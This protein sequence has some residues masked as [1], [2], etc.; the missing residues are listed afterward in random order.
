MYNNAPEFLNRLLLEVYKQVDAD[1][2]YFAGDLNAKL[3][4]LK[5]YTDIDNVSARVVLD[6]TENNHG[7]ALREFLLD[8]KCCVVNSRVT[9]QYDNYTFVSTRGTSVVDYFISPHDCLNQIQSCYVD[10]CSDIIT[11]LDAA[12]LVSDICR[13][14]DHSLLTISVLTSPYVELQSRMLGARNYE[15][16]NT[17]VPK[18]KVRNLPPD[19]MRSEHFCEIIVNLID[20]ISASRETQDCVDNMYNKL[21]GEIHKEMS[22]KLTPLSMGGKRKNTPYK[23]YWCNELSNLWKSAHEKEKVYIRYK[24]RRHVKEGLR[25]SFIRERDKFDKLLKRRLRDHRRGILINAERLNTTDPREFW[26][27]I[28]KLGPRSKKDIPWEVY[29]NNGDV[30]SD[31]TQVLDKW[32]DDYSKLYNENCGHYDDAF[33]A[34]ILNA[35]SHLERGMQDPLYNP[36]PALNRPIDVTEVRKA[37]GHAKNGKAVG[38]DNVPNEILKVDTI[39]GAL[40]AFFQLCFDSSKIPSIWTQSV[41]SPIPKNRTSDPRVPLNYRGISL[42]SCVY[43]VYSSIL[44]SRL[45]KFL[46]NNDIIHDEQN[47]FRGSRSCLDHIFTLSSIIRNKL[48]QKK[49]IFACYV[50]FRK[51]F[52]YLDRDLMLYRFLEYGIDGRFYD[53]IKGIYHRAFCAVKI[54]GVMSDWFKSTQGTKQGDNLSP[55]CFSLYLNPLLTELKAS[56]VGV[57]IENSIISVL[58]YADDLVLVAENE[59]D[60]QHLIKILENW[61]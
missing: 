58:A 44:N 20:N 9:P 1:A 27:F 25:Q 47:G 31:R 18:Y 41:I 54:N 24:G 45:I 13:V 3:G 12:H 35:K 37:I 49:E 48:N 6:K 7:K 55:N 29:D 14:P 42:L 53:A 19:F 22:S 8:A 59:S 10:L 50:D 40:H 4:S 2:I 51:A 57:S 56:R 32:K 16:Q 30:I 38:T 34:D 28:Q 26:K 39:L 11:D 17:H 23:P 52:D 21:V 33:R 43:K 61:C 15:N 36:E 5:D 60:L 46:E